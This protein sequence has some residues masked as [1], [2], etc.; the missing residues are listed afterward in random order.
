MMNHPNIAQ[1]FDAGV[2]T[3]H[4]PY[5]VMELVRGFPI[6]EF[7]DNH[8]I[9]IRERLNLIIDVCNAVH[10]AHQK[11]II[12]RDIKPSNVMVTLHDSRPV[13][14][15][16]DFG[17]A[18]AI[19]QKLTEKT[20]YTRFHSMIGT[21]LYMSPE[22]AEMSG[23]DIDTRSD[24]Y[25]LGVLMYELLAGNTPFDR[26]PYGFG[27]AWMKCGGSF[28]KRN[29]RGQAL[30]FRRK[31]KGF[32]QPL[33]IAVALICIDWR[34]RLQGDLDWIVMKSLWKRIVHVDTTPLPL[35]PMTFVVILDE[36]PIV[37]R[38]PSA[39]YQ[40][41]KFARRNRVAIITATLVGCT[42]ILGTVVLVCGKCP[43]RLKLGKNWNTSQKT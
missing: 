38:P 17:V 40:F 4:R 9:N 24:I 10:H 20:V 7:C 43:R 15:V 32:T 5:F 35:W 37:A 42:M 21:P 41:Q 11:G 22:Q 12:H 16:I 19:G 13:A 31:T 33:R 6:T 39:V 3:D 27:R 36:K 34:Q 23:L 25:S 1:V 2:T 8:K 26:K 30:D 18:K 14:K 29:R 28:A